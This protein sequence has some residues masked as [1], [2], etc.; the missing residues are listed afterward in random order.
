MTPEMTKPRE[1]VVIT[2]RHV[3]KLREMD[4]PSGCS[5]WGPL[6]ID[7][8]HSE[9]RRA[10]NRNAFLIVAFCVLLGGLSVWFQMGG[11]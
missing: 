8:R 1:L 9:W 6:E 5:E 3:E 4:Y 2:A 11:V 7:V 10:R